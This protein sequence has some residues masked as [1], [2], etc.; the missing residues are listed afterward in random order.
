MFTLAEETR[1]NQNP[2]GRQRSI[3]NIN[4]H[5][6]FT[7]TDSGWLGERISRVMTDV[8]SFSDKGRSN[9][10]KKLFEGST[11]ASIFDWLVTGIYVWNDTPNL[12]IAVFTIGLILVFK[13]FRK[14]Y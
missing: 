11:N 4:L 1:V 8:D 14:V 7:A 9:Y 6:I 13:R 10:T 3:G 12:I 5:K 2:A